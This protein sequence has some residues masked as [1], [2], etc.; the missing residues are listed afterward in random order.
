MRRRVAAP[1]AMAAMTALLAVGGCTGDEADPAAAAGPPVLPTYRPVDLVSRLDA[2]MS[3]AGSVRYEVELSDGRTASGE[4]DLTVATG[5]RL[6]TSALEPPAEYVATGRTTCVSRSVVTA[7]IESAS[8]GLRTP[9]SDLPWNCVHDRG[10]V[11]AV[12]L[13]N[14]LQI[15]DP[16]VVVSGLDPLQELTHVGAEEVDGVWLQHLRVATSWQLEFRRA[17][18]WVDEAGLPVRLEWALD[19]EVSAVADFEGWGEPVDL[20]VPPPS[21]RTEHEPVRV[22]VRVGSMRP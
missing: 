9:E 10:S 7:L 4:A 11:Y 19:D 5:R 6:R 14:A 8:R 12:L 18:L 21:Q 3:E 22:P 2:A 16:V 13:R 15:Y 17:D 1:A 20:T